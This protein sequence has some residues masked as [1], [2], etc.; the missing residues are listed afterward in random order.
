MTLAP[1]NPVESGVST[2]QPTILI[3]E[4]EVGPREALKMILRPFF[5]LYSVDNADV[6]LQVLKE[7]PIDVVTLDLKLPGRQGMEVLKE[8]KRAHED[9]EVIII[10]GYGSLESAI[11]GIRYGVSAYLL[12]PFDVSELIEVINQTLAKKSR[13][14]HL[15]DL[16][17]TI[18]SLWG[19]DLT[20]AE[21][22][23]HLSKLLESK[24]PELIRHSSRVNF[25]SAL[26]AEHLNLSQAERET[27]QIGAYLHDIG[28][29]GIDDRLLSNQTSLNDQQHEGLRHHPEIGE[30]MVRSLPFPT[31][32]AQ[33]IRHH[34]EHYDGSGYPDHLRGESIPLLARIVSLANAF[35]NL[36]TPRAGHRP[37]SL[38]EA[39]EYVRL[40]A[41]VLFDPRLAVLFSQIVR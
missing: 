4:D 5:N 23:K 8:I 13:L 2:L 26:L 40:Q 16:L 31:E 39:R 27:L 6:A 29:V 37:L 38:E 21:A 41:G 1:P 7:Q 33:I 24:H 11:E 35:D 12:K 25:Y 36:L 14:N 9:V 17:R 28:K 30:R 32:V 22:W 15:R 19:T 20:A 34:H 18:G 10:T 3:V